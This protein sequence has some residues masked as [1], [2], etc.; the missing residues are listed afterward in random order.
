M[1]TIG[2]SALPLALTA[3]WVRKGRRSGF[4]D[5]RDASD[6]EPEAR[7]TPLGR[8]E[9]E[10]ALAAGTS[11]TGLS[12]REAR[13]D[14]LSLEGQ[15]LE[16]CDARGASMTRCRLSDAR[17]INSRLDGVDLSRSDLSG[18]SLVGTSLA[19]ATLWRCDLRGADLSSARGMVMASV[20][21]A[22]YNGSTRWPRGFDA[23]AA[24]AVRQS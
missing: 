8:R 24:G 20:R 5:L 19:Q 4:D 14:R 11:L 6:D 12:L 22:R 15:K 7:G 18:A 17:I 13:L 10:R 3:A 9:L 21:G 23:E 2:A 16:D 1:R